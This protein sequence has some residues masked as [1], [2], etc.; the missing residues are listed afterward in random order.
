[1]NSLKFGV[2]F[3]VIVALV[4]VIGGALNLYYF[5]R[6]YTPP[7]GPPMDDPVWHE[8]AASAAINCNADQQCA[9]RE[10]QRAIAAC[11]VGTC[12]KVYDWG[13][14]DVYCIVGTEATSSGC[15]LKHDYNSA[16]FWEYN[17]KTDMCT[18]QAGVLT[19]GSISCPYEQQ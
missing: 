16:T 3:L 9:D 8:P 7:L 12:V 19:N 10:I 6:L 17:P 2:H 5:E 18:Y 14:T 1:M 11:H 13:R 15:Q 4:F